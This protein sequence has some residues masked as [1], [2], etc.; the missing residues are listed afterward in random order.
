MLISVWTLYTSIYPRHDA[1]RYERVVTGY[2][3]LMAR[4]AGS[5]GDG[6][7]GKHRS[8]SQSRALTSNWVILITIYAGPQSLSRGS[9][10][11]IKCTLLWYKGESLWINSTKINNFDLNNNV[12][13]IPF[14]RFLVGLIFEKK[15]RLST[16]YT[17]YFSFRNQFR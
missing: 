4:R 1:P 17:L 11:Q 14:N 5:D 15:K 2:V 8:R 3:A 12:K 10:S 6:Y 7:S 9:H 13:S 16:I